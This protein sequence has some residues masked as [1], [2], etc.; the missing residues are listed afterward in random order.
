MAPMFSDAS[1]EPFPL[2]SP[3]S[4]TFLPNTPAT[5]IYGPVNASS[6]SRHGSGAWK[7]VNYCHMSPEEYEQAVMELYKDRMPMTNLPPQ[8]RR[9]CENPNPPLLYFGIPVSYKSLIDYAEQ[10][11][12]LRS[13]RHFPDGICP[14]STFTAVKQLGKICCFPTLTLETPFPLRPRYTAIVKLYSNY[15]PIL[16][17]DDEAFLV[18]MI[19]EE[20]GLEDDVEAK[21]YF[22]EMLTSL[23][24]RFHVLHHLVPFADVKLHRRPAVA[25]YVFVLGPILR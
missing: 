9:T 14:T 25:S 1:P 10:E 12:V 11:G 19:K 13:N 7:G 21:W 17:K 3:S 6:Y 4:A 5:P 16:V 23:A 20:L 15:E 2:P 18:A 8:Y 24:L 22:D